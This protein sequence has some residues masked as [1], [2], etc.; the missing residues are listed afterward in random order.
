[1]LGIPNIRMYSTTG[2]IRRSIL[3]YRRMLIFLYVNIV[4]GSVLA[5]IAGHPVSFFANV[6]MMFAAAT[7]Y[8]TPMHPSRYETLTMWLY[9]ATATLLLLNIS[10]T[11]AVIDMIP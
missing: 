1:M 5:L 6:V 2:S 4:I 7:Y 8:N 3:L 9:L 10:I 11:L